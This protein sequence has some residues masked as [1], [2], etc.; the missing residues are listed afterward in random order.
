MSF[1]KAFKTF[2]GIKLVQVRNIFLNG[3]G[4]IDEFMRKF[5]L[6]SRKHHLLEKKRGKSTSLELLLHG[7]N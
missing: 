5:Y 4:D 2:M 1:Y 7:L 3:E 6:L